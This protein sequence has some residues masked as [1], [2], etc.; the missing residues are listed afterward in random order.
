MASYCHP[1]S[2]DA[3]KFLQKPTC[4][5]LTSTVRAGGACSAAGASVGSR[6]A[7]CETAVLDGE[8]EHR[9]AILDDEER[10]SNTTMMICVS[11]CRG[12]RLTLDL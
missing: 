12:A 5:S 10:A 11:R 4:C 8:V 2:S 3:G 7:T 1:C 9:D 6:C